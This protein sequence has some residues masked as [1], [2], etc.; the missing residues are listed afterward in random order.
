MTRTFLAG[1]LV[2]FFGV[3]TGFPAYSKPNILLVIA[4]DMGIDASP[5]YDVGA[6]KPRMPNLE[7]FCNTG[8]VF[9][10]F[11]T[12]PTSSSTRASMVTGRYGFRTGVGTAIDPDSSN[13]LRL[14]EQTLFQALT[15][16]TPDYN[17]AFIGKW[18]LATRDNGGIDHPRLAGVG[19]YSG[20]LA[21]AVD[22]YS[23]WWITSQGRTG[24]INRY[25]T[26]VLTDEAISWVKRQGRK[27]WF[28]WLAHVAPQTPLHLPPK[29]FYSDKSL[30]GSKSSIRQNR[31]K[32]YF[33]ALE[34]IDKELGRLLKSMS[35]SV[36]ENT[37]IMFT[38]D[39]GS[40]NRVVQSPYERGRAKATVFDG[41]THSPLIVAGK[42]VH[43]KGEREDALI[44]STD[45]YATISD[46]A[47]ISQTASSSAQ[48]S[49]S[50][51]PLLNEHKEHERKYAYVEHFAMQDVGRSAER[52]TGQYGW[53][54]RDH[55]YK[56]IKLEN[57][58]EFLFD[59]MDDLAENEN[60]IEVVPKVASD[61]ATAGETF[62]EN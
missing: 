51:E 1:I 46:L 37:V 16:E 57:G 41:G 36:R 31:L 10:N 26:S 9:D 18:D 30:T 22:D 58:G 45:I 59:M 62:R 35:K 61:L 34:A 11:Y 21:G 42:G 19:Y 44:N 27:P 60:L 32:Y 50:F 48:D 43:R 7:R 15:K 6:L 38:G 24:K 49:I 52:R 28:L 4:D 47:G 39:N 56:Y 29:G 20:L 40:P 2:C 12:N 17:H 13:G 23:D 55:Q 53:A 14:D 3:T 33:A 54:I 8:L 25:V 5:C